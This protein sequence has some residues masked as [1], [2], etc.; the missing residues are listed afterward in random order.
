MDRQRQKRGITPKVLWR[1]LQET[2][3]EWQRDKAS[4][5]AAALSYY[6]IFSLAP[7]IIVV[8]AIA[9]SLFG[10]AAA[11]GRIIAQIE[12]AVGR[13]GAAFLQ[14]LLQNVNHSGP[15]TGIIASVL[16][17]VAL[18]FGATGLFVELQDALNT[19]WGVTAKPNLG[20]KDFFRKRLLSFAMI[21]SIGFFLLLSL[22]VSAVLS[23]LSHFAATTVSGGLG[24]FWQI[25]NSVV[26]LG[27]ITLLFATIY[28]LL[29]DVKII[30]SD[31]WVGA[32]ITSLLFM[33]GRYLLGL[34]LG[35]TAFNSTYGAA[36]SLIIL[37]VWFYYSAQI[38]FFGAEFTQ[39]YASHYGSQIVPNRYAVPLSESHPAGD[40]QSKAVDSR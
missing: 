9:G 13:D 5:L 38:L 18:L 31:V 40:S 32:V 22:I 7:L 20:V 21:L 27:V 33:V 37:L 3:A 28:K 4:R 23:A 26:S 8:I 24:P 1:L 19:V 17:I 12:G 6:A 10:E 35:S 36:G 2:A 15:G 14:T 25:V 30:W 34:Y 29:P 39:V 16:G 11:R